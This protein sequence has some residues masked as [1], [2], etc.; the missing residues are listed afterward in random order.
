MK[1]SSRMK[2][3]K[4]FVL[5]GLTFTLLLP[6]GS[7]G[8]VYGE[9]KEEVEITT[10]QGVNETSE[11]QKAIDECLDDSQTTIY[12]QSPGLKISQPVVIPTGKNI[13]LEP[14]STVE[15]FSFFLEESFNE[16]IFVVDG[17]LT[18]YNVSLLEGQPSWESLIKVNSPGVVTL[19]EGKGL[20]ETILTGE[21]VVTPPIVSDGDNEETD[22]PLAETE[23]EEETETPPGSIPGETPSPEEKGEEPII[24]TPIV[25]TV[26]ISYD[27][28]GGTGISPIQTQKGTP[29]GTDAQTILAPIP[30]KEGYTFIGWNTHPYGSGEIM[31]PET[32]LLSDTT[33]YA[34][35]SLDIRWTVNISDAL[36]LKNGSGE[37][38]I[39]PDLLNIPDNAHL[40]IVIDSGVEKNGDY[41][42]RNGNYNIKTGIFRDNE[43]LK[44]GDVVGSFRKGD[45]EPLILTVI[46]I[47]EMPSVAGTYQG[48]V[49][50]RVDYVGSPS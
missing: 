37:I 40:E 22:P 9:E 10:A 20:P 46:N 48:N 49:T 29:L 47:G 11:L 43:K 42:L 7:F 26:V 6:Q 14:L 2:S 18:M 15:R 24:E 38:Q 1:G 21:E 31:T 50:F 12:V 8:T 27:S 30:K 34:Q 25:E 23:G 28:Q 44:T 33:L 19:A 39:T 4:R 35:W 41:L 5:L 13:I 32:I 45:V 3:L 16:P 36:T 17:T